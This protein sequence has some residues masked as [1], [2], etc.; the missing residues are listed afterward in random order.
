MATVVNKDAADR[1][2]VIDIIGHNSAVAVDNKRSVKVSLSFLTSFSRRL[3]DKCYTCS[4]AGKMA[5][6]A[7][8]VYTPNTQG[9]IDSSHFRPPIMFAGVL[10]Y[11]NI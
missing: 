2:S 10:P 9:L 7:G 8:D 5:L 4:F 3:P 11:Y 1:P 6:S